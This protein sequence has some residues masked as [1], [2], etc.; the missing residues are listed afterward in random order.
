MNAM[1]NEA[2]I[3]DMQQNDHYSM[4]E[5]T[6]PLGE[7]TQGGTWLMQGNRYIILVEKNSPPVS[8]LSQW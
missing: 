4:D 6:W 8:T 2:S 1:K 5:M 7:T 3:R